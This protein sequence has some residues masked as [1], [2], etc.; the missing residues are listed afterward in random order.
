MTT[1]EQIKKLFICLFIC[2]ILLPNI[3][4]LL[5]VEFHSDENRNLTEKPKL[6]IQ[7]INNFSSDYM[8]Y[9]ED[10]MPF[11]SILVKCNAF[12][13]VNFFSTSPEKAVIL[14]KDGWLFYNS[15]FKEESNTL[16]DYINSE[17]ISIE[18]LENCKNN[19]TA[20]KDFCDN[21]DI[22]FVFMIAPNK[23]TIY[24]EQFMPDKYQPESKNTKADILVSYLKENTD[25]NIVYPKDSLLKYKNHINLYYKLDSHW[26]A[27]G[28]YIG[29]QELYKSIFSKK[30]P[31]FEDI[32][33]S[34]QVIR[35]G[36]LSEMIKYDQLYD[37]QYSVSY[38]DDISFSLEGSYD[39]FYS[40]SNNGQGKKLLIFRDSFALALEQ[41]LV[42]DFSEA[43][44]VWSRSFNKELVQA[45]QPD[46]VV[47]EIAE[48]FA[49]DIPEIE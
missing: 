1:L 19:L 8:S 45:E 40:I 47:F 9:Y 4:I 27:L 44:F 31:E 18:K 12:I 6:T 11:K 36:D 25:L 16:E 29:Y 35:S 24:G 39:D 17:T 46:I 28:S 15:Q 43:H 49:F 33:Y 42:K 21:E 30:L 20:M 10:N 7:N 48:R 22:L 5:G 13:D 2:F 23:M 14:G 32:E 41:Y 3:L 34:E 37:T 38:N 26:N